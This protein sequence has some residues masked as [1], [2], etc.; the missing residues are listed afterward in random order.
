M[1]HYTYKV[2]DKSFINLKLTTDDFQKAV[3]CWSEGMVKSK[4]S[5]PWT[6]MTVCELTS[7]SL[8]DLPSQPTYLQ[9]LNDIKNWANNRLLEED[10]NRV[11]RRIAMD[12]IEE[13]FN[14]V[15]GEDVDF[16][17]DFKSMTAE[18][19]DA[20]INPSHYK[21]IPPEAYVK[22]PEGMEYMHLM[23]YLL[24]HLEGHEAHT[25]GHVF[26]YSVRVGK[27]DDKLQDAK[28]I[29]WY[30]NHMVKILEGNAE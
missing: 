29:A 11:E 28:K 8:A 24:S 5:S 17:G 14:K 21:L 10:Y 3:D 23:E 22:H 26:K 9:T 25:M 16:H 12:T 19:Q 18:Q 7:C 20:V 2:Y 15:I 6:I 30:A 4:S 1:K 13:S 27:K